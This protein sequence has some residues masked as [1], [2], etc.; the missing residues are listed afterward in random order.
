MLVSPFIGKLR[1]EPVWTVN[2][3]KLKKED[4][5]TGLV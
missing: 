2:S 1:W 4:T 3:L 5:I